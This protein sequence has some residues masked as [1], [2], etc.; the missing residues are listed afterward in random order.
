[1]FRQMVQ[2]DTYTFQLICIA[3]FTKHTNLQVKRIEDPRHRVTVRTRM[4]A[5][6]GLV[7]SLVFVKK[8]KLL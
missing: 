1:M 7:A 6:D 5:D 8:K 4:K 2:I 3:F